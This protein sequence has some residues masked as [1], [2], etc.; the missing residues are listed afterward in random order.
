MTEKTK[1]TKKTKM[2]KMTKKTKITKITK[3]NLNFNV[4]IVGDMPTQISISNTLKP[5]KSSN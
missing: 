2:T 3:E 5:P 4:S 1:E